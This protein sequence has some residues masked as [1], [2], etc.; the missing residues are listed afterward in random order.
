MVHSLPDLPHSQVQA[1]KSNVSDYM[2]TTTLT[3]VIS[4]FEYNPL[5]PCGPHEITK[6]NAEINKNF[7]KTEWR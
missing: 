5:L 1:Y 2:A 3:N 4:V 6:R 7:E